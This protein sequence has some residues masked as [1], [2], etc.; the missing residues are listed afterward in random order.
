MRLLPAV[1][2]LALGFP[3]FLAAA[4][5]YQASNGLE[6][7][8]FA[9]EPMVQNTVAVTVD[10][11]GRV[12]ATSV[13]RR[14]AADLDIR[15][16]TEW[17]ES[18]LSLT[19]IE[20]KRAF[21][22]RELVAANQSKYGARI[23][24]QNGDGVAD[25]R[26]L[27]VLSDRIT[28]M[29]DR[30]GDGV[31]DHFTVF[32]SGFNTEVTGIAAGLAAWDGALYATI[33][34]DIIRFE[35]TDRDGRSDRRD[36]LATGFSVHIGYAGHNFSGPIIGLD[37]RLYTSAPDRGLHVISREGRTFVN[38]H[39]GAIARCEF[40]GSNFEIFATGLRNLQE[41][42]FDAYGNMFGLDN[43]GDMPGERERFVY[44]TEGSDHGWRTN[45]QYRGGNYQPWLKESMSI[46]HH[47]GQPAYITPPIRIHEDGPAGFAFNPGTA[48]NPFYKDHFFLTVFPGRVLYA[49]KVEQDGAAYRMVGDHEVTTAVLMVGVEF[50][51]DGAL[52]I[53]DW[54]STGY[55]MNEK[56]GV[57]KLDDP[58]ETKSELRLSTAHLLASDWSQPAIGDLVG[59][60]G[61]PDQRV[62]MKAQFEIVR[63]EDSNTLRDVAG[64]LARPQMARLHAIWGLGQLFR[65]HRTA[66]ESRL[67]A[68]LG[69][70]DP[71]VRALAARTIGD[72]ARDSFRPDASLLRL[73]RDPEARPR[74][75][76]A[77]ALGNSRDA[78]ATSELIEYLSRDGADP[79]HRHAAVMGLTGCATIGQLAALA[80]HEST[81][82]RLGAIVALRRRATPEVAAFLKVADLLVVAEA[83]SA[84]HDDTSI[85]AA[86]PA[87]ARVLENPA[88]V[89]E[90][91]LRRALS[92]AQRLRASEFASL[93]AGFAAD[94]SQPMA[95]RL[96][97]L[98]LI[99]NWPAPPK[100]DSV[101][102]RYRPLPDVAPA[103]IAEVASDALRALSKSPDSALAR[104]A[105]GVIGIYKLPQ[106]PSELLAVVE[107]DTQVAAETL[108][109]LGE[110]D[111]PTYKR[112]ARR[113]IDSQ[114]AI[115]RSAAM[116]ALTA[117]ST[118]E[119]LEAANKALSRRDTPVARTAIEMFQGR[120]DPGSVQL[121]L[122]VLARLRDGSLDPALALDA[123]EAAGASK[124][125]T[126]ITALADYEKTKDP[127]DPLAPYIETLA[128]GT[129]DRGAD[130]FTNSVAVQCTLCHSVG[131]GGS[132]VGPNLRGVGSKSPR[133]I[134]ESL[135]LPGAEVTPGFG[136]VS[137]TLRNGEIISG[138]LMSEDEATTTVKLPD[139]ATRV[140][141]R[142]EIEASTPPVSPMPPMGLV[143]SKRDVRDLLAYLQSLKTEAN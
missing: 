57:W 115:V 90:R 10:D 31:A 41:P 63:R 32:D 137:I 36:V 104:A 2:A 34:P 40:D 6:L 101:E 51:S 18:D 134:L 110:T 19:S 121:L 98:A 106:D 43:D 26:D 112:A 72:S 88:G 122:S 74:F 23:R 141:S 77:I 45:W 38:P 105:W 140:I 128:G 13:V 4:E 142:S 114:H 102:G 109:L 68:L 66:P 59:R 75:F 118:N 82:V 125:K 14:K 108:N 27:Q 54:S 116:R 123:V 5:I 87:L 71:E 113:A 80:S 37:G 85:P 111:Q 33:E 69:D 17:I 124:S 131:R 119:F 91:T 20:E 11:Q 139:G 79:Y 97:A 52:Y 81:P 30:D 99:G 117:V 84:I 48:L 70:P 120:S 44:V 7:R 55:E 1:V 60:L 103:G 65:S 8:E 21:L 138:T 25:W 96:H 24:D 129:V 12:Y 16:F 67:S 86:F 62:R 94:S 135:V 130:I 3:I 49:F 39:S 64:D 92:A 50:G 56:G 29:E 15:E 78:S 53:A 89:L 76:A 61:H 9:R 22:Q 107:Q 143:L 83:A 95:L 132:K 136:I 93:V 73:L 42:A 127:L 35:D 47:E 133:N 28:R 100:L 46:P 126:M 58:R